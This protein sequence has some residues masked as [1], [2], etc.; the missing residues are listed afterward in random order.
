MNRQGIPNLTASGLVVAVLAFVT[1]SACGGDKVDGGQGGGGGEPSEDMIA[2]LE[3]L[4]DYPTAK[5]EDEPP[6]SKGAGSIFYSYWV[7]DDPETVLSF[8]EQRVDSDE[9][10]IAAE[11]TQALECLDLAGCSPPPT[12]KVGGSPASPVL[13]S[14]R[15]TVLI[16]REFTSDD[17]TMTISVGY[18]PYKDPS[19]GT[20][21]VGIDIRRK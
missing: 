17:A 18:N 3:S 21:H 14:A 16:S 10:S 5:T 4:P 11:R 19:R 13:P 8:F 15:Q 2:K 7:F 6:F 1:V 20:T 12:D 9:W